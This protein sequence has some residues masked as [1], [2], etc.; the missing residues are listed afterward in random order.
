[1]T[2]ERRGTA[3]EG[4]IFL[5]VKWL[6]LML[7]I[8]AIASIAATAHLMDN[9]V[10]T[11][12][13]S[14]FTQ[15]IQWRLVVYFSLGVICLVWYSRSLNAIKIASLEIDRLPSRSITPIDV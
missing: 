14:L 13:T 7:T 15:L 11:E 9:L 5:R 4:T 6:G 10:S 8:A 12:Y 1:L 2:D 3:P